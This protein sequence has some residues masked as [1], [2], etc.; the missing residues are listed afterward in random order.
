[1]EASVNNALLACTLIDNLATVSPPFLKTL[2]CL[3]A[4]DEEVS[5]LGIECSEIEV[6]QYSSNHAHYRIAAAH[7]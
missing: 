6:R 4:S 5:R 7:M 2:E 3:R 1:M